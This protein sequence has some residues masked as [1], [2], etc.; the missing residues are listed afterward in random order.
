MAELVGHAAKE[1]NAPLSARNYLR[2]NVSIDYQLQVSC[3]L[4]DIQKQQINSSNRFGW[5]SSAVHYHKRDQQLNKAEEL[6]KVKRLN[7]HLR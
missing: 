3:P 7:M 6:N 4:T 1:C 5:P 2:S